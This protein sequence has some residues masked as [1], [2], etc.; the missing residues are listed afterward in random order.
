MAFD[1]DVVGSNWGP[2]SFGLAQ[3]SQYYNRLYYS[4]LATLWPLYTHSNAYLGLQQCYSNVSNP[5]APN[6][7][8]QGSNLGLGSFVIAQISQY[9]NRLYYSHLATSWPL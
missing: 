7:D 5:V 4:H 1:D 9:Y 6:D 3:I 2:G 8:V